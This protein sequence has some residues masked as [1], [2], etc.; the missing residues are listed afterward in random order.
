ME[1]T[2]AILQK[3]RVRLGHLFTLVL[4]FF[5]HPRHERDLYVLL[6]G[7][8]VSM[9]GVAVRMAAAGCISKDQTLSRRGPY[10]FTRNPLYVGSF[11][12]YLGFCIASA[13]V[14]ITI[15]FLPFFFI[16]YYATIFR[17]EAFLTSKFGE[18]YAAFMREVPR[19]FPRLTPARR[20]GP[21]W[22]S[23]QQ[24]MKNHEYEGALAGVIV[25]GI[26]WVMAAAG[27]SVCG[28]VFK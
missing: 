11:L 18:D 19:F 21:G 26:L 24:A 7:T 27:F 14:W 8:G 10:A 28:A 13:N 4:L 15:G 9:L 3:W 5:A 12:L 22:F 25:L 2:T 1:K 16:I 6:I 20:G 23:W 17:E